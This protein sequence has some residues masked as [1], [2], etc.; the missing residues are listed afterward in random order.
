MNRITENLKLK[1]T[2][3]SSASLLQSVE[4]ESMFSLPHFRASALLLIC[5]FSLLF[6][7]LPSYAVTPQISAGGWHTIALKSD[8]TLWAWGGNWYGQLGDGTTT[9]KWT[10]TQIGTDN[11]WVSIEAGLSQMLRPDTLINSVGE[12]YGFVKDNVSR[13]SRR[14]GVE[15]TP[16]IRPELGSVKEIE[17]LRLI[18]VK[19]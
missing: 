5:F 4:R 11:K 14:K 16:S 12:L 7:A 17:G 1:T 6:T 3:S 2:S 18:G 13:V 15:Q 10:P 8:G 19:R 9:D